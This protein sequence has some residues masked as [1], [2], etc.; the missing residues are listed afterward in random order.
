MGGKIDRG[1]VAVLLSLVPAY[2][3][4]SGLPAYAVSDEHKELADAY[5]AANELP[6]AASEASETDTEE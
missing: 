1:V 2:A 5:L 3:Q 6:V 4:K